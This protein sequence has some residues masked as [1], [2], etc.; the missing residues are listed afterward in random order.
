[1]SE[2]LTEKQY[3]IDVQAISYD[4]FLKIVEAEGLRQEYIE[5]GELP[6]LNC[7]DFDSFEEYEALEQELEEEMLYKKYLCA[8]RFDFE[9]CENT[10][11]MIV[12]EL[13]DLVECHNMKLYNNDTCSSFIYDK[14]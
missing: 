14:K 2:L 9:D 7:Q 11:D 1:M 10:A 3:D 8:T 6:I 13:H 12:K 4:A 5:S